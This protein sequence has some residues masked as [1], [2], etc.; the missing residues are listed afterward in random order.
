MQLPMLAMAVRNT[1]ITM[2]KASEKSTGVVRGLPN[3]IRLEAGRVHLLRRLNEV[4]ELVF[5][6]FGHPEMQ[7]YQHEEDRS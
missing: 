4:M 6:L 1:P 7:M 5:D 2:R 3:R